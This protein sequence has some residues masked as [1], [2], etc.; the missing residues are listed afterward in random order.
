M[1]PKFALFTKGSKLPLNKV[2]KICLSYHSLAL[3]PRNDPFMATEK[4]IMATERE[5]EGERE[6][7]KEREREYCHHSDY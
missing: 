7:E 6:R 3:N 4:E 1:A 5:R 2:S